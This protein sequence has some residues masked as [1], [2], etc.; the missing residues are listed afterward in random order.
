MSAA[1][2]RLADTERAYRRVLELAPREYDALEGLGALLLS[3]RRLE[4]AE[5]FA[6]RAIDVSSGS[7]SAHLLLARVLGAQK[8][9]T[10][11]LGE[12]KRAC[13]LDPSRA[14]AWITL[15]ALWTD[16]GE[17]ERSLEAFDRAA[18]AGGDPRTLDAVRR[19]ARRALEAKSGGAPAR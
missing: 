4:E 10:D 3:Q 1:G 8:R 17:P 12:A 2:G 9:W 6:R 15:G 13:D 11:A 18:Q 16:S 19:L 14:D 5:P 7:A